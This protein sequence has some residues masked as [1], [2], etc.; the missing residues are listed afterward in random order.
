MHG[1]NIHYG[2]PQEQ[3]L[4]SDLPARGRRNPPAASLR[5]LHGEGG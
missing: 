5:L 1:V 2:V 3:A 4:P